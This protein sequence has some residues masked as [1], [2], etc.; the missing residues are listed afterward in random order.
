MKNRDVFNRNFALD[1]GSP[2]GLKRLSDG[3]PAGRKEYRELSTSGFRW[4][5]YKKENN[6][7]YAWDLPPVLYE[8][9][10]GIEPTKN[11]MIDYADGNKDNLT[12]ANLILSRKTTNGGRPRLWK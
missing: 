4:R 10:N 6:K 2:T 12:K 11:Q 1:H 7:S 5:V 9:Y 3:T 8:L